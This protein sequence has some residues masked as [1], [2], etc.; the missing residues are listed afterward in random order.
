MAD[1]LYGSGWF[2]QRTASPGA[3]FASGIGRISIR[4]DDACDSDRWA[5]VGDLGSRMRLASQVVPKKMRN[6][7]TK[8]GEMADGP[9]QTVKLA[10]PRQQRI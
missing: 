5:V 6:D 3:S 9:G 10:K 1:V 8:A 4:W 2:G 7:A